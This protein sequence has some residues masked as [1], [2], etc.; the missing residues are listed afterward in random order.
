ILTRRQL[1]RT[2]RATLPALPAGNGK[3]RLSRLPDVEGDSSLGRDR[4]PA[5]SRARLLDPSFIIFAFPASHRHC[6]LAR[7][8][9][10]ELRARPRRA[11]Q[12]GAFGFSETNLK[13]ANVVAQLDRPGRGPVTRMLQQES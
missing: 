6:R 7:R 3:K 12:R 2:D 4:A 10:P 9:F 11:L 13:F 5:V 1:T 8:A